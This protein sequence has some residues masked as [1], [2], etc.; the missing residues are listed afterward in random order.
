MTRSDLEATFL[1]AMERGGLPTPEVNVV[2]DGHEVDFV[3]RDQRV[4][5]ELDTYMTHG[6]RTAF[7]RDR[8]RDRQLATQPASRLQRSTFTGGGVVSTKSS[9]SHETVRTRSR[10]TNDPRVATET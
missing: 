3:W 2:I 9:P 1:D 8:H 7:E 10:P 6:S 4:I 5:A